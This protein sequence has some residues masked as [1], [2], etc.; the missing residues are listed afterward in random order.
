V[1]GDEVIETKEWTFKNKADWDEGPWLTEP[2][3]MQWSDEA[4]GYP[5]LIVRGPAGALCGYVGVT[6][7]HPKYAKHYHEAGDLDVHGGLTYSN[8][9][10]EADAEHGICH[11]TDD[12]D[13]VWWFGFDCRHGS[14]FAPNY[15]WSNPYPGTVYRTV[16]YVKAEVTSLAKQLKEMEK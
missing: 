7:G 16:E 11:V 4:T 3:K 6:K 14:D 5:C 8:F 12:E 1:G 9:C 2:D 15:G 10:Q 13:K